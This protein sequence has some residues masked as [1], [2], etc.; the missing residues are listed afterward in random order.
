ERHFLDRDRADRCHA[1]VPSRSDRRVRRP[2]LRAARRSGEPGRG[3]AV[4]PAVRR[5]RGGDRLLLHRPQRRADDRGQ[6]GPVRRGR[7]V[8]LSRRFVPPVLLR[9][10]RGGIVDPGRGDRV[11]AGRGHVPDS[12]PGRDRVGRERGS[13]GRGASADRNALAAAK[14]GDGVHRSGPRGH[15]VG[16]VTRRAVERSDPRLAG[17]VGLR[18]GARVLRRGGR[19]RP[20]ARRLPDRVARVPGV[21][22]LAGLAGAHERPAAANRRRN[23]L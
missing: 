13:A 17:E 22:G 4:S 3:G 12:H 1:D 21:R 7:A 10:A 23:G 19:R 8:P 11:G 18:R 6:R 2:D 20:V 15:A 5:Q 9:V 16:A 14:R